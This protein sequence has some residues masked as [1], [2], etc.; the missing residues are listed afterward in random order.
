MKS[1]GILFL[2]NVTFFLQLLIR[3]IGI[4]NTDNLKKLNFKDKSGTAG[5]LSSSST[6][7]IAQLGR[8]HKLALLTN[9]HVLKTTIPSL[10]DLSCAEGEFKGLSTG[11]GRVELRSIT[12][13]GS[14]VVHLELLT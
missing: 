12:L 6:V 11:N 5:N 4:R 8:N 14:C 1:S 9:T 2:S 3:V 10:N 13:K 7:S